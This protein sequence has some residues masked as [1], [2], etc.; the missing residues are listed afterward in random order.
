[1]NPISAIRLYHD[2]VTVKDLVKL[3][4]NLRLSQTRNTLTP[5]QSIVS[6]S[7]KPTYHPI[8]EL[9]GII[10]NRALGNLIKSQQNKSG[11]VHRSQDPLLSGV[12]PVSGQPIQRMPM[13]RG[14]S[15]ELR[16]NWS[17][18]NLVQ[19]QEEPDEELQ[20]KPSIYD[21][22]RS[23]QPRAIQPKG[24]MIGNRQHP[25][26]EQRPNQTGLP[27]R[28][29]TGIENLSGYLMD[30]VRVHYSSAKP[31]KLQAAAYTQ[32][33]LSFAIRQN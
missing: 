7:R 12:S 23:P 25:S 14:L 27:D 29:K 33:H 8:E 20:P 11:Q 13:F 19:R 16:G 21:L 32:V 31:A 1:M 10:G 3:M 2:D 9:Q 15:H 4:G 30:D 28:L 26:L 5:D 18:G 22:Q 6:G 24:D 17:D